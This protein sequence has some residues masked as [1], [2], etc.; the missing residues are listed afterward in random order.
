MVN[1]CLISQLRRASQSASKRRE[2]QTENG[3]DV[4]DVG[5]IDD[6]VE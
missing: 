6:S 5:G 3:R 1:S 4:D 2:A